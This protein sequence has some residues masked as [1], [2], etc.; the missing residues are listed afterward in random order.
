MSQHTEQSVEMFP[1]GAK[2]S[3]SPNSPADLLYAAELIKT[4]G[5]D[6]AEL[7][8][9][10]GEG[11]G[12]VEKLLEQLNYVRQVLDYSL[13]VTPEQT[14]MEEDLYP[15]AVW[16][17]NQF[18]EITASIQTQGRAVLERMEARAVPEIPERSLEEDVSRLE[19][20]LSEGIA[21][22]NRSLEQHEAGGQIDP[23]VLDKLSLDLSRFSR[24]TDE[25]NGMLQERLE[26][27]F[28]ILTRLEQRQQQQ[29]AL[30]LRQEEKLEERSLNPYDDFDVQV[31]ELREFIRKQTSRWGVQQNFF[32]GL[33][34][35]LLF[36]NSLLLFWLNIRS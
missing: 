12:Q 7:A 23:E 25:A 14:E 19:A 24:R 13:F 9:L 21:T 36:C 33:V 4:V 6:I 22:I 31:E 1:R 29:A 34:I 3:V 17:R 18:S 5:G 8:R 28:E 35:F 20:T 2:R 32:Y 26:Q 16:L 10:Q 11:Q 15:F 30:L 27:A